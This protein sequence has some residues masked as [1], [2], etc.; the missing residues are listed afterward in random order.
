VRFPFRDIRQYDQLS[1]SS[2]LVR[3]PSS[4]GGLRPTAVKTVLKD[5]LQVLTD[6]RSV[7]LVSTWSAWSA[8]DTP[9]RLS[10]GMRDASI[11]RNEYTPIKPPVYAVQKG[12]AYWRRWTKR[13]GESAGPV[14]SRT[15]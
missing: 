4:P 10:D 14:R 3:T 15:S 9:P 8:E 6:A 7:R 12:Q 1:S 11:I 13:R 5:S 2:S